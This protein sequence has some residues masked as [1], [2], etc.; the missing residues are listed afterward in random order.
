VS[1]RVLDSS[2]LLAIFK[3]EQYAEDLLDVIEG[4]VIS[5]VN[6]TEVW[7]KL[8]DL[9][10]ASNPDVQAIFD[11]LERVEPLTQ[12]QAQLAADLRPLTKHAGLSLGDRACLA[13]AIETGG[14]V[15]TADHAWSRV[16]V[17]CRIH[18]IR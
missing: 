7:T 11:L 5:A 2:V 12:S 10:L 8:H 9:G 4:S 13:L 16:N 6:F 3:N 17:G 14:E 15:Y 18:A 1:E